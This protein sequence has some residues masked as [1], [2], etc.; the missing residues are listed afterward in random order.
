[1]W[2]REFL[3]GRHQQV[4][5]DGSTS[6]QVPVTSGVPQ[7]TVLGP[8]LFLVFINDLPD[9][10]SSNVRLFADDC[11]LYRRINTPE[12]TNILQQDLRHLE[13]WEAKWQMSFNPQKC[14]ILRVTNKV[15]HVINSSY[16]L[17]GTDL[18][19]T[20]NA[21]YLGVTINS[22]LKW[23]P[24]IDIMCKKAN[25]TR[26]F[27]QRN[28]HGCPRRAK[29]QAYVTYVRPILEYTSSVWDPYYQ[30]QIHK[31]EMVQR[32]AARFV[33]NDFHPRHSVTQML[34]SLQWQP[35]HERRAHL[36]VIMVYKIIHGYIAIPPEP[37]YLFPTTRTTRRQSQYQQQRCRTTCFMNSF[38]PSATCLWSQLPVSV[39]ATPT[40]DQ[41]RSQ[42]VGVTLRQPIM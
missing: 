35:L 13:E 10:V 34:H 37:P 25:S 39:T 2:I 12:D 23:K 29:E 27:I 6:N 21:K 18:H 33:M 16:S 24:H 11:L 5:L 1:M 38:F 28:L 3:T 15:K 8:L 4:V 9:N 32:R 17:H 36:K 20:N 31:I 42:L 14:E 22:K 7:G 30:D 40:L 26:G 41:F 19:F